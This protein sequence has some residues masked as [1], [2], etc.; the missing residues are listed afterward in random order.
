MVMEESVSRYITIIV[1][2]LIPTYL[3]SLK[4]DEDEFIIIIDKDMINGDKDRIANAI[5]N[6]Y[7]KTIYSVY[8]YN[9][10]GACW[11]LA[12]K[13]KHDKDMLDEELKNAITEV[14]KNNTDRRFPILLC[15]CN[16]YLYG[17][18]SII[19]MP[20]MDYDLA[21]KNPNHYKPFLIISG[22]SAEKTVEEIDD[23]KSLDSPDV[24]VYYD[25]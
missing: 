12:C 19:S 21:I 11:Y 7:K 23:L 22:L 17:V 1:D 20:T 14:Q 24:E 8:I 25:A 9:E 13:V 16:G 4:D 15:D 2:D 5:L 3:G 18:K 6:K 10:L